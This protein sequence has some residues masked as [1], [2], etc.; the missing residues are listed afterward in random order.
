MCGGQQSPL[1]QQLVPGIVLSTEHALSSC[2][3]HSPT[4]GTRALPA[5]G[6]EEIKEKLQPVSRFLGQAVGEG[7]ERQREGF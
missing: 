1:I 2:R 4:V 3:P 7:R 5:Q 6:S